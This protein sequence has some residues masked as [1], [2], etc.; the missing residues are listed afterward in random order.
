[1]EELVFVLRCAASDG[2]STPGDEP[3][4]ATGCAGMSM[5]CGLPAGIVMSFFNARFPGL[6]IWQI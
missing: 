3:G 2:G 6:T 5:S 1:M 4:P